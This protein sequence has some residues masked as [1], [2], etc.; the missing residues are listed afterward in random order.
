MVIRD[1][2]SDIALRSFERGGDWEGLGI[3]IGKVCA[4]GDLVMR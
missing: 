1:M 2:E 3:G 4:K